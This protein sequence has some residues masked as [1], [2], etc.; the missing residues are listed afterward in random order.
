[1][2]RLFLLEA[3]NLGTYQ[4]QRRRRW[5]KEGILGGG[6]CFSALSVAAVACLCLESGNGDLPAKG[7]G[8]EEQWK[9]GG[10]LR[11]CLR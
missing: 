7:K 3:K 6:R 1:M 8:R 9:M 4:Q 2:Q 10:A 11:R 5:E